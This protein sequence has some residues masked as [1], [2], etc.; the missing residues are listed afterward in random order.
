MLSYSRGNFEDIIQTLY[1]LNRKG[2][3]ITKLN[4][5]NLDVALNSVWYNLTGAGE[6]KFCELASEE[7]RKKYN[8]FDT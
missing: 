4:K 7:P 8:Y 5:P 2:N 1:N 6:N 3:E